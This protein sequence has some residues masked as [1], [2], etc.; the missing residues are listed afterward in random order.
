MATARDLKGESFHAVA[1]IG[2]G[3]MTC[4]LPFEG[5][6]NAGH[7]DRDFIIVLNDNGMSIAPNVGALSK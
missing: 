1:V 4:G 5:M 3:A 2:D 6:N 7:S